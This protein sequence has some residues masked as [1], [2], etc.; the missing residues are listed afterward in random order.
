MGILEIR[1][2]MATSTASSKRPLT[3][4]SNKTPKQEV[5]PEIREARKQLV[6][7]L[8]EARIAGKQAYI[9]LPAKLIVDGVV[10]KE[11][12]INSLQNFAEN[13]LDISTQDIKP[14][15]IESI[16]NE[17]IKNEAVKNENVKN[18]EV[19]TEEVSIKKEENVEVII[20][21]VKT[22]E[23]KT[24]EASIGELK[25]EEVTQLESKIEEVKCEEVSKK[26]KSKLNSM[27]AMFENGAVEEKKPVRKKKV[28]K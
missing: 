15:K 20:E 8:R 1:K 24:E 13:P 25:N 23:V 11:I 3:M 10:V 7:G 2:L 16:Q 4:V 5:S 22:E 17:E 12:D 18:I 21:E 26:P 28:K 6:K 27:A 14:E 9:A 19:K